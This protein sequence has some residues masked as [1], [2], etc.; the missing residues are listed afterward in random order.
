MGAALQTVKRRPANGRRAANRSYVKFV[1]KCLRTRLRM[2][3][4]QRLS[5]GALSMW[6]RPRRETGFESRKNPDSHRLDVIGIALL[7]LIHY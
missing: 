7:A 3:G 1:P 5:S 6:N 2:L 4:T